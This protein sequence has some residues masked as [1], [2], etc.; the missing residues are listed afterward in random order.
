MKSR[1]DADADVAPPAGAWIETV[2]LAPKSI[3][4]PVAPPAGAWIETI[5]QELAI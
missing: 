3:I 5:S 4:N 1:F 2:V